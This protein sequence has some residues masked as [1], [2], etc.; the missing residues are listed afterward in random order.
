[1]IDPTTPL[2]DLPVAVVDFE[3]TDFPG[4]DTH[5][6]EVAVVHATLGS[7]AYPRVAF[8]SL[9]RPPVP[10]PERVAQVHGITDARVK[11]APTWADVTEAVAAACAGR[12]IVAFNAP[13]DFTFY[14]TED[15]RLGRPA[16]SWPWLDLLVVRKATKTRGRPGKLA[17]L[18]Q[19]WGIALDA[20]GA[21]GDALTTAMLLT[22]LMRAAWSAGA[23]NKPEGAQPVRRWNSLPDD[24]DGDE[25]KPRIT[26]VGPLLS[27]QREAALWQERDFVR[28]A[29]ETG[30]TNAP[31]TPWHEIESIAP[32]PWPTRVVTTPCLSC[33]APVVL[34][35]GRGG[36]I[37]PKETD[38][39]PHV[40]RGDGG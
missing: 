2:R 37:E 31:Q 23:F 3:A 39:T 21:A 22:P 4:P 20:H 38:G 29:R 32:P 7:G 16:P 10:I 40:C 19:E 12:L 17:E 24:D 35:V 36:G 14:R 8:S 28:Y 18:A 9:V 26:T 11:D 34:G 30:W 25:P 15:A 13:A 5:V 27:W 6:C 33:S 1:M